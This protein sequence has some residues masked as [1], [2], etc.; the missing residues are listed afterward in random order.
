[1]TSAEVQMLRAEIV[2]RL[3]RIELGL[4]GEDG[5][6]GLAALVRDHLAQHE[7]EQLAAERVADEAQAVQDRLHDA[8]PSGLI[9]RA[10]RTLKDYWPLIVVFLGFTAWVV[11]HVT[12]VVEP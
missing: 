4:F 12:I 1:M 8:S 7:A 9:R 2:A 11:S 3:D 5:M 6:G 10:L